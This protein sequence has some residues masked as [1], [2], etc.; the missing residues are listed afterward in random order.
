MK[1]SLVA[2]A[3]WVHVYQVEKKTAST[4]YYISRTIII[5]IINNFMKSNKTSN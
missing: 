3:L 2:Y 5:I 1:V 4:S